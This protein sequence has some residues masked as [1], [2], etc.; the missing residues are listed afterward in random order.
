[1]ILFQKQQAERVVCVLAG[2]SCV[3]KCTAVCCALT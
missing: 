3:L 2:V 1:M